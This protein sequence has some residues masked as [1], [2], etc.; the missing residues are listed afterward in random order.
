MIE[1]SSYAPVC[2]CAI[3]RTTRGFSVLALIFKPFLIPSMLMSLKWHCMSVQSKYKSIN[4][5]PFTYII[6]TFIHASPMKEE[7][8]SS[9]DILL[10]CVGAML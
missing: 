8:K 6:Y 3:Y 10:R 5:I 1:V 7:N 9:P 4:F 2:P